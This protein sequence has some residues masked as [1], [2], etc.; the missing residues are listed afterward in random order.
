MIHGPVVFHTTQTMKTLP[1]LIFLCESIYQLSVTKMKII[2][3]FFLNTYNCLEY[4]LSSISV[5]DV[6]FCD[7]IICKKKVTAYHKII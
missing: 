3:F 6:P 7:M 1:Y 4:R 5:S 2:L